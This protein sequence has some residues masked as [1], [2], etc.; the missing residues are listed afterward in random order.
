MHD[1]TATLVLWNLA[2]FLGS[3]IILIYL[4]IDKA[5]SMAHVL[6][7]ITCMMGIKKYFFSKLDVVKHFDVESP[8]Q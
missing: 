6:L 5:V 3:T 8:I 2:D 4:S 1:I 7:V